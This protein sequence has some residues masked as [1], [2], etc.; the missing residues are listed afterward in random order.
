MHMC[1]RPE[2]EKLKWIN[3]VKDVLGYKD[4]LR[5]WKSQ[6]GDKKYLVII[7]SLHRWCLRR[8]WFL[9]KGL[10]NVKCKFRSHSLD[11]EATSTL[12]LLPPSLLS[13]I[14][15]TLFLRNPDPGK[16]LKLTTSFNLGN[17]LERMGK[18]AVLNTPAALELRDK[19]NKALAS[20]HSSLDSARLPTAIDRAPQI[21]FV[22][23]DYEQKLLSTQWCAELSKK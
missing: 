16:I 2:E 23:L 22:S 1:R 20:A 11:Q 4:P 10:E 15:V 18:C 6:L 5:I 13:L 12:S 8:Q 9:K 21:C 17:G 14:M 3:G 7:W 19:Q